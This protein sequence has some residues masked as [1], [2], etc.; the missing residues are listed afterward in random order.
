MP[1]KSKLLAQIRL[2]QLYKKIYLPG[3]V[4]DNFIKKIFAWIRLGQIYKKNVFATIKKFVQNYKKVF[5]T[6]VK[7]CLWNYKKFSLKL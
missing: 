1:Y 4:W 3:F 5:F 2:G 6:T 7:K